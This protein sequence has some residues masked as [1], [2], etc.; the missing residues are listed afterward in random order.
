M[1]NMDKLSFFALWFENLRKNIYKVEV[2]N[3]N[4]DTEKLE[5]SLKEVSNSVRTLSEL[6]RNINKL[7]K[8]NPNLKPLDITP[9]TNVL[10]DIKHKFG[11]AL[12]V[13]VLNHKPVHFPSRM[14]I[15][16]EVTIKNPQQT[17]SLKEAENIIQGLQV[18]VDA[19]N[20]LKLD[21]AQ[22]FKGFG[23]IVTGAAGSRSSIK[24]LDANDNPIDSNNPLPV[25]TE[26]S[27]S[28]VGITDIEDGEGD[29]IMDTA[30]NSM[31][32]TIVADDVGI[33]GGVQ[34]TENA[35]DASITGTVAMMEVAGDAVEPIQGTVAD[36]LLVNLGANNDVTVT[37]A[38]TFAV[39]VDG[40]A[41]TSLQNIDADLT[42]IKGYV[43]GIET[44]LGTIDTDTGNI[45]TSLNNIEA[46]YATEGSALGSGVLLQGD[47]GTDRKN[48]NVDATTGDVQV[49][50][51]NTVTVDLGANNDVTLATLPDT[52]AGDLAAQTTDLAAIETLLI[53]I[54][55]D[56]NTIQGDTTSIQ[57]AV[58]LIDNIIYV[59][60]ADWVDGTS[61][62]ALVGGL[63]QSSPQTVTD[64]DVAPFNITA[65]GALHVSQQGTVTVDLGANNDV[66]VTGTVTA[67]LSA[68][69]NQVLDNIDTDLTTIIGHVD[70]IETVLGTIDADTGNIATNTSNAATSLSVLDDWDNGASDGAS[71]SGDVAHDTADAG[72]PVKI[73]YKAIAL[74]STPTAVA[75]NDRTN[76]Y[77]TRGGIP[78]YIGGAP[79]VLSQSL[80]VTDAD[81]AQTDAAI[82]T[83]AANVA[84]VVTKVSVMADNANTGDV[85]CRIGLATTNT[86]AADAAQML[87]FHP[88]IAPGSGVVEGNGSGILGIGASGEDVRVTCE[89]PV[90]GSINIIVTYYT[91]SI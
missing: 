11:G 66:T 29:S 46:G 60:D 14:N 31:K 13:N 90:G 58:E 35:T 55:S 7:S 6:V 19:I 15:D 85:S 36:G 78:F 65:N 2:V 20:D 12:D 48:I 53:G 32:M 8:N 80:Q 88:G 81:G 87:L 91:E 51:T 67:N 9:I 57:T 27:I 24:I 30:N 71:V 76:A 83:A 10:S 1:P 52:A 16:G 47:D 68:T 89:D 3:Q 75:A 39:Q 62:H 61:S 44:L 34:Y 82:I 54:D 18:V 69:D 41:L 59:D 22:D 25:S 70:G 40:D 26:V 21:M 28:S 73:G 38:G 17:I 63:Y 45:D 74:K 79:N 72:E 49:D 4:S 56:T 5:R 77:A 33:G 23:N 42:D 37:N 50:V 64:G 84:I 43:D 86:P